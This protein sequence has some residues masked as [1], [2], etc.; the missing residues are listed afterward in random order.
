MDESHKLMLSK[1]PDTK[2][3]HNKWFIYI[4]FKDCQ[5]ESMALEAKIVITID[6][7]L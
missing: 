3:V 4:K 5:N 7:E 1:K 6:G 2:K